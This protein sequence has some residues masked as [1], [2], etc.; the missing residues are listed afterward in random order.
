MRWLTSALG[1]TFVHHEVLSDFVEKIAI[2]ARWLVQ[3][4]NC[5]GLSN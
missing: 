5:R 4:A 3:E 1:L 2:P